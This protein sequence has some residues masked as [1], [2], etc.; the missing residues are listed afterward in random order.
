MVISNESASNRASLGGKSRREKLSPEQRKEI[1]RRAAKERWDK[2]KASIGGGGEN[3]DFQPIVLDNQLRSKELPVARWPG[4]LTIGGS[5][6][7]CYVLEDKRRV[8]TRTAATKVL[9]DNKGGGNLESYLVVEN[10]RGFVPPGFKDQMIEF[11]IPG[12]SSAN[13]STR[14]ISAETFVEICQAY[15]SAFES[16]ALTTDRQ[17]EIA[18]KAAMF[19]AACAKVGLIAMIDEA[20]GYQYERASD[21]LQIKLRL[22]L[23][24][25]MRKWEKTFPDDLWVQFG[26]LTNWKGALH[27]RPKY[28]GNLVMELIYEYLDPD[29]AQW[30]R[31][32]AP[33]PRHGQNYFQWLNEQYG[34]KKLV[35]H[36]WKVV[37]IAS[38]CDDIRELKRKMEELYGKRSGFQYA[39]KLVPPGVPGLVE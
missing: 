15:V 33:S 30:L 1:A 34:L 26:R 3:S 11:F 18:I 6:I 31:E 10:L 8:I 28:W 24:E 21:A 27:S 4:I 37:G 38:T 19:L 16:N 2:R 17:K 20:T 22:F 36:I 25:E 39:L 23:A 29:V 35:E 9:T 32:N 13:N 12:T 5:D 14:G 7:P